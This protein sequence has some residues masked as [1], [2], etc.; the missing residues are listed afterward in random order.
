MGLMLF[1]AKV[2][3]HLPPSPCSQAYGIHLPVFCESLGFISVG[4]CKEKHVPEHN[5]FLDFTPFI[6]VAVVVNTRPFQKYQSFGFGCCTRVFPL[7][8]PF[9]AHQYHR[10]QRS[11]MIEKAQKMANM[12]YSVIAKSCNKWLIGK[13]FWKGLVLPS[14]LYGTNVI[15]LTENETRKLQIIENGV[16]ISQDPGGTKV[17]TKL[18]ITR[19]CWGISHDNE[20]HIWSSAVFKKHT[21]RKK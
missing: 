6:M 16:G 11:T 14:V 15:L 3:G 21:A 17:C 8:G 13:T 5:L 1:F 20:N 7:F 4:T 19:G 12:T 2:E 18:H 9:G 10:L